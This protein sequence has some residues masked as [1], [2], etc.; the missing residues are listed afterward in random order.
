MAFYHQATAVPDLAQVDEEASNDDVP[1][2]RDSLEY[3]QGEPRKD[4]LEYEQAEPQERQ[5]GRQEGDDAQLTEVA[6]PRPVSEGPPRDS[7]ERHESVAQRLEAQGGYDEA[8]LTEVAAPAPVDEDEGVPDEDVQAGSTASFPPSTPSPTSAIDD[9]K[10]DPPPQPSGTAGA[11]TELVTIGWICFFSILGTLARLGVEAIATYPDAVFPSTV[12]WANLGGSLFLGFLLEDRRLFRYSAEP[13]LLTFDKTQTHQHIDKAKKIL[14]LYIGLATGF[15][16]SFTSYSTFITDAFLALSNNLASPNP[17]SPYHD[18]LPTS[19]HGGY[20]FMAALA[21]LIVQPAVSI[22]GLKT[23]AH[24]AV[25]VEHIFPSI[26][27]R[28]VRKYL[29]FLAV[30]LGFG[31]WVGAIVLT[32]WPVHPSWRRRVTMALVFS[33]PGAL[34]RFYIS[35]HLNAVVVSFP[36][37][38]FLTNV[39]GTCIEGLCYDLQHADTIIGGV[40]WGGANSCA[41]LEGVMQGFCGCATT[42]STWVAELNGLRRRHAWLYGVVSVAVAGGLQ[43]A[44]MGSVVWTVGFV[45]NC[46]A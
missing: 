42:V 15:C 18:S 32:L 35:K 22:S 43:I 39:F 12:L 38:T 21:I 19:R 7:L 46:E 20:S 41:V 6:A 14:P 17:R 13:H 30:P 45:N 25:G 26:P 16:G 37:G 36:V 24:L 40:R 29:D 28:F 27:T 34:A 9:E 1:P 11:F 23:G 44:I 10:A 5:R 3:E 8:G 33:P 4:S 2:A 31:C